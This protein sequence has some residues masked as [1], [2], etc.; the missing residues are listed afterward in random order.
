MLRVGYTAPIDLIILHF[1]CTAHSAMLLTGLDANCGQQPPHR[2]FRVRCGFG[3]HICFY[4]T[5]YLHMKPL[6]F[7]FCS[8]NCP[9]FGSPTIAF[10]K[11]MF[12]PLFFC[13]FNLRVLHPSSLF[14]FYSVRLVVP[15][16]KESH[17]YEFLTKHRNTSGEAARS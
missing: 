5:P 4:T 2:V 16:G 17:W 8:V 1:Q 14:I 13:S 9:L 7:S 11:G 6:F 3:Q 15:R 10:I 12:Q